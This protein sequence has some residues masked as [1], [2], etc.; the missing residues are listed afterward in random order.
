ML[1]ALRAENPD[2]RNVFAI[3]RFNC[4]N[5]IQL[6]TTC[7]SDHTCP[8]QNSSKLGQF[9]IKAGQTCR[10]SVIPITIP[11]DSIH[12]LRERALAS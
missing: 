8:F 6:T 12:G 7:A 10:F 5:V 11:G 9:R 3:D 4:W 2:D 1:R